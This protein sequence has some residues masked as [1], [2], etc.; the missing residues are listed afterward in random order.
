MNEWAEKV[1]SSLEVKNR[2]IAARSERL[3]KLEEK[4]RPAA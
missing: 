2:Q 1:D 4:Q 3:H